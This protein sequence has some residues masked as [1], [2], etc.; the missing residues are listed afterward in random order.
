MQFAPVRRLSD[1]ALAAVELRLRGAYHARIDQTEDLLR[2]ASLMSRQ[3]VAPRPDVGTTTTAVDVADS[4][5]LLVS[6]DMD[7]TASYTDDDL[8]PL[9]DA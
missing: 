8:H 3:V 7:V 6:I 2:A 9:A 5:P 1:G 4:L